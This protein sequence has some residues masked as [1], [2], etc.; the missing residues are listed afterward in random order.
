MKAE[1]R[2]GAW[3]SAA[4]FVFSFGYVLAQLGE[5]MGWLGSA[6]G[7]NSSS[8][9][10]GIVVLLVPSLLLGPSW[11]VTLAALHQSVEKGRKIY[12]LSA[13]SLGIA[14]AVLTG[15]VYFVQLTLV[16]PRLATGRTEGIELLLF[17]PYESFLFAIDLYGYTLMCLSALFAAPALAGRLEAAWARRFL[18][19][20]GLL[21]PALA[22][23]M[24]E[25]RLIWLGALWGFTFPAA[26]FFLW[27][28]FRAQAD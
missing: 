20:T 11:V 27:K 22:F 26:A 6:G 17:R 4:A 13:L 10:F 7:P 21:W 3:A 24:L 25:P 16:A 28:T 23:Q 18:L 15:L 8:T 5:W 19:L 14:Y 1:A 12:S 2:V 9:A